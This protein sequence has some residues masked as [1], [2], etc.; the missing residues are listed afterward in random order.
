[1]GDVT[2]LLEVM[3]RAMSTLRTFDATALPGDDLATLEQQTDVLEGNLEAMKRHATSNLLQKV[4][5]KGEHML[6]VLQDKIGAANLRA[7][8]V[9]GAFPRRYL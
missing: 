1:M 9:G 2:S 3:D 8:T 5:V 4:H 7:R 6:K